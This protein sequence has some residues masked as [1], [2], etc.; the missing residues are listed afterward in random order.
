L[1]AD[2]G[3]V[4]LAGGEMTRRAQNARERLPA[5]AD[6]LLKKNVSVLVANSI[7]AAKAKELTSSVPIVF[8]TGSDPVRDGLVSSLN[9]PGA[10]L[11]GGV[12]ITGALAA[13][14]L[15]LLREILPAANMVGALVYPNTPETETE[16]RE[17]ENAAKALGVSLVVFDVTN[18]SEIESAFA[19]S[20]RRSIK[21]VIIGS[22]PFTFSKRELIV[23]SAARHDVALVGNI[24]EYVKAGGL[25]SYGTSITEAY[26]QAGLY[27]GRILKGESPGDLPVVQSSKFE[28]VVNLKAAK[29]LHVTLPQNI[30]VAADEVIE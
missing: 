11:T 12:F 23:A 19:D 25:I 21:G 30:L 1:I 29:A 5:L 9:H 18:D 28:M 6:E 4:K 20:S 2:L 15:G 10:N 8:V 14:R 26:R 3:A 27:V 17:L 24:G 16:R 22:G 7:A 13:K